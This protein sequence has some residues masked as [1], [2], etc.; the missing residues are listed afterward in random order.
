MTEEFTHH[1]NSNQFKVT[2]DGRAAGEVHYTL[3]SGVA[4]F[5]HTFVAPEFGGRGI[6]GRLVRHAMDEVR[7]E[8]AWKVRPACAF[9]VSWFEQN[10]QDADLLA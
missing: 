3:E 10:P 8:G 9:V 4:A 6:A 5:D 2:V 1:R 7:A